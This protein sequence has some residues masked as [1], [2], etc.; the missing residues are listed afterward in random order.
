MARK[1]RKKGSA[2]STGSGPGKKI[3]EFQQE[4]AYVIKDLRY[5]F[6]LAGVMFTILILL[7][8]FLQ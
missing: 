7:N 6:I 5:I 4:Y 3:A 2:T 1:N 8:L